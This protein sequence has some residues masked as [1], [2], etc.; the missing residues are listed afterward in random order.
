MKTEK[1]LNKFLLLASLIILLSSIV[2]R[3]KFIFSQAIFVDEFPNVSEGISFVRD[4]TQF[5]I[6]YSNLLNDPIKPIFYRLFFGFS[7]VIINGVYNLITH[8]N[9]TLFPDNLIIS[10]LYARISMLILNICTY[11]IVIKLY[12]KERPMFSFFLTLFVSLNPLLLFNT[13]IAET[14]AFVIPLSLLFVIYLSKLDISI[15][16]TYLPLTLILAVLESVQYY[17]FIFVIYACTFIVI[18][19]INSGKYEKKQE[20]KFY[21]PL[22]LLIFFVFL[23]PVLIFLCINPSY[24]HNPIHTLIY[25]IKITAYP[26]TVNSGV[27]DLNVFYLGHPTVADP[28]YSIVYFI[29]F[30][31]PIVELILFIGGTAILVLDLLKRRRVDNITTIGFISIFMFIGNFL[32]VSLVTHFRGIASVSVM[33][34]IPISLISTIAVER[35]IFYIMLNKRKITSKS[36]NIGNISKLNLNI[37]N[38]IKYRKSNKIINILVLIGLMFLIIIPVIYDSSP[39]FTYSNKIGKYF[40]GSGANIDGSLNSGQADMM[41]AKFMNSHNILNTTVISLANTGDIEY[42]APNNTYLQ[43]WPTNNPVNSSYLFSKYFSN[44]LVIDEYYAQLYG[45]PVLGNSSLFPQVTS[46]SN[47]EGYAILYHIG[48]LPNLNKAN[49]IKSISIKLTNV[50]DKLSNN[51]YFYSLII[52]SSMFKKFELQNLTN[53]EFSYQNSS[54]LIGSYLFSGNNYADYKTIYFLKLEINATF[55]NCINL[56]FVKTPVIDGI[57]IGANPSLKGINKNWDNGELLFPIYKSAYK[58]SKPGFYEISSNSS[59]SL[60]KGIHFSSKGIGSAYSGYISQINFENSTII[61]Q[62]SF[63]NLTSNLDFK[64]VITPWTSNNSLPFFGFSMNSGISNFFVDNLSHSLNLSNRNFSVFFNINSGNYTLTIY[65][66]RGSSLIPVYNYSRNI[67][68][69]SKVIAPA[70]QYFVYNTVPTFS[71]DVETVI[72]Y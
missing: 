43:F 37:L 69:D 12:W 32:F 28:T 67:M 57:Y 36:S 62:I 15:P 54:T 13:S 40:Y 34:L 8:S 51:Q 59:V 19:I 64:F 30:Q 38:F 42:Y 71:V 46:F 6:N 7:I 5:P 20:I 11:L 48:P 22:L 49:I 56:D 52:N 1:I 4:L 53:V 31:V 72:A 70:F 23:L 60:N 61:S 66:N 10:N 9:I 39:D 65:E 26:L 50:T 27:Y 41:I 55:N 14:G 45:N 35:I 17:S 21:H 16:R 63:S 18:Q 68:L 25:T 58:S 24:W 2:I 3:L 47:S 33:L 44:Y 29:A